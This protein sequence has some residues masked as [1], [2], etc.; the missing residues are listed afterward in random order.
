MTWPTRRKTNQMAD[1]G[2]GSTPV[3]ETAAANPMEQVLQILGFVKIDFTSVTKPVDGTLL[4][5]V[6]NDGKL[7]IKN[8]EG[9]IFELLY[10]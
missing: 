5:G 1:A 6:D 10:T 3:V 2:T 9:Y 4:V 7:K 8:S